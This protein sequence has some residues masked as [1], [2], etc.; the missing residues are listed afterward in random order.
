MVVLFFLMDV[1]FTLCTHRDVD[2]VF[3]SGHDKRR[4]QNAKGGFS[5]GALAR[6]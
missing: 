1:R 4:L 6:G 3:I 2:E 5:N